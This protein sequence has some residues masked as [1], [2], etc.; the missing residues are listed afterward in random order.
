MWSIICRETTRLCCGVQ[1]FRHVWNQRAN[2]HVKKTVIDP[3][4]IQMNPVFKLT[5]YFSINKF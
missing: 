3:V 1:V 4:L 5:S 2:Y